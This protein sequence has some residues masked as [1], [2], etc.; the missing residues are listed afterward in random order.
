ML[1]MSKMADYGTLILTT[2]VPEPERIQSA[3][4][5][6]TMI[7]V[8]VPTVSKILKIL[9]REGLVVSLRGAKGGYMLSRPPTQITLSHIINAM[10]GPIGMT[11][12]SIS[13]GLCAQELGCPVRVNWQRVNRI[14]LNSL[15]QITLNQMIEPVT[16]TVD[17]STLQRTLP[18]P[19]SAPAKHL[20]MNGEQP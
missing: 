3:A 6:A 1:R 19:K 18:T 10:D 17:I 9:T 14:V 7:R 15:D 5:I 13:P 8:P 20:K 16:E 11:E 12:C 4:G 2:M